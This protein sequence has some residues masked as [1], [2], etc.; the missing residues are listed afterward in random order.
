MTEQIPD[1]SRRKLLRLASYGTLATLATGACAHDNHREVLVDQIE[2]DSDTDCSVKIPNQE[3]EEQNVAT[4]K[5]FE[6]ADVLWNKF[7][8]G[9]N[10]DDS[11]EVVLASG[12]F[13]KAFE[14]SGPYVVCN[15]ANYPD[16]PDLIDPMNCSAI[17]GRKCAEKA[18][19]HL[20]EHELS[21][22]P[23]VDAAIFNN[24]WCETKEEWIEKM[25]RI[26]R[27][28]GTPEGSLGGDGETDISGGYG[29]T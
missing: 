15:L 7:L 25:T 18:R 21:G 9:V 4:S 5:L 3:G 10:Y 16:D 11:G 26:R 24:A 14:M 20:E 13:L 1:L 12:V 19:R 29:C 2:C 17:C 23:T 6:V 28:N 8:G 27:M 22:P